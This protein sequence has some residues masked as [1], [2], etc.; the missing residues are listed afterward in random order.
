MMLPTQSHAPFRKRIAITPMMVGWL[1]LLCS[2]VCS[3]ALRAMDVARILT[4]EVGRDS[5]GYH[6]TTVIAGKQP[7]RLRQLCK[8]ITKTVKTPGVEPIVTIVVKREAS[9][10]PTSDLVCLLAACHGAGFSHISVESEAETTGVD[11]VVIEVMGTKAPERGQRA[12]PESPALP[13]A[14]PEPQ[15]GEAKPKP[16]GG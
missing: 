9:R 2:I 11:L 6:Y 3:P 16:Q 1:V 14:K 7:V 15:G 5:A 10:L 12:G 8:A 13:A 4:I